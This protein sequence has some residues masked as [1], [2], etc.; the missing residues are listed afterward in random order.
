MKVAT[1]NKELLD[2]FD[3]LEKLVELKLEARAAAIEAELIYLTSRFDRFINNLKWGTVG[4]LIPTITLLISTF[5][6][7]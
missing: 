7:V 5:V 2:R 1:D 3:R 6:R 4:I